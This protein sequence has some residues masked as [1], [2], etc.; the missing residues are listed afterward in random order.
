[1][2]EDWHEPDEQGVTARVFGDKLD[3]AYGIY[4]A[5]G[6]MVLVLYGP[7]KSEYAINLADLLAD[8]CRLVHQAS[9]F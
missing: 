9:G 6:E 5:S 4:Q 1:M 3:N 8:Y 7:D 2:R